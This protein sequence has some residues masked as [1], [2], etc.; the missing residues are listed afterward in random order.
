MPREATEI[1]HFGIIEYQAQD[2]I[3]TGKLFLLETMVHILQDWSKQSYKNATA[4]VIMGDSD[5]LYSQTKAHM[6]HQ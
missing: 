5:C 6:L 3:M 2:S 4:I 1:G